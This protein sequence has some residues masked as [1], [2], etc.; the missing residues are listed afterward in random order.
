[1]PLK[2]KMHR[3]LQSMRA[4][5]QAK[6]QRVS[7]LEFT[8]PHNTAEIADTV[9][10]LAPA[11]MNA[12]W[13]GYDSDETDEEECEITGDEDE[14][15]VELVGNAFDQMKPDVS[16]SRKKLFSDRYARRK[17]AE[18]RELQEEAKSCRSLSE[19]GF[20]RG[21]LEPQ[22][23][24]TSSKTA[25]R[26]QRQGK[27]WDELRLAIEDIQKALKSKKDSVLSL[28]GQ[29]RTRHEAVLQLMKLSCARGSAKPS[30]DMALTVAECYM[31]GPYFARKILQWTRRW[32]LERKIEEGR[33]GCF[34]KT[35]SWFND[36]GVHLAIRDYLAGAK[37]CTTLPSPSS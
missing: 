2:S 23:V 8:S 1:M 16:S 35:A 26:Q 10:S 29:N 20:I 18:A 7:G 21:P 6:R 32:I 33:Q 11:D 14:V 19:Y 36:E 28:Q 22:P 5:R 13:E 9:L 34:S 37:D 12:H 31:K 30:H 24:T 17:R 27:E 25:I 4:S 15:D 3:K